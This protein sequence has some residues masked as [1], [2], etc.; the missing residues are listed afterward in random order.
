MSVKLGS[1]AAPK[2]PRVH[3]FFSARGAI[4]GSATVKSD[5]LARL[6]WEVV[7]AMVA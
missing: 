1:R 7:A 5:G 4:F 3:Q 6:Q 2:G